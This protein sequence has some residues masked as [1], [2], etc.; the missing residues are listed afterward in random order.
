MA[1]DVDNSLDSCVE[2]YLPCVGSKPLKLAAAPR[3]TDSEPGG[4]ARKATVEGLG[5]RR[6][7]LPPDYNEWLK[8]QGLEPIVEEEEEPDT[9]NFQPQGAIEQESRLSGKGGGEE[10]SPED[11]GGPGELAS[12]AAST[13]MKIMYAARVAGSTCS[14]RCSRRQRMWRRGL[15]SR[16]LRSTS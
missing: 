8:A 12:S 7:T 3:V 13:L 15:S 9:W 1:Y 16:I 2:R 6:R 5:Q 11:L 14:D 4:P 10:P